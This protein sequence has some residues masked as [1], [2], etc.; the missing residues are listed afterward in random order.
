MFEKAE[1]DNSNVWK[2]QNPEFQCLE[3]LKSIIPMF[4][5]EK[6]KSWIPMFGK[7]EIVNFNV[8]NAKHLNSRVYASKHFNAQAAQT[9]VAREG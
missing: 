5:K 3:K 1:I 8:F 9:H 7:A 4:R 6:P 2:S